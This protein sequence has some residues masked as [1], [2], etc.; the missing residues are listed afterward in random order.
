ML[1]GKKVLLCVT[2]GI[3]AYKS[4]DIAS[5][6]S[7]KGVSV[8]VVMS[9]NATKFVT[10]LSF[11]AITS[12]PVHI[13]SFDM[14]FQGIKH[15]SLAKNSDVIIIAPATANAI[16]KLA[17]GLADDLISLTVLATNKKVIIAPAMNVLM[18]ES[19]V[20][21]DNINILKKRGYS[22][23]E[24]EEGLLACGDFGKGK[25]A[26]INHI[27]DVITENLRVENSLKGKTVLVTTG[28]TREHLD[29]VRF[30]SNPSTGKM[31]YSVAKALID[32][33]ADV[34]LVTGKTNIPKNLN[35]KFIEVCSAIEMRDA[36]IDNI[37][38]VDAVVFSAAVADY[39]PESYF[40]N[41][42]KKSN[43]DLTVNLVRNP[44]IAKEVNLLGLNL[45]K[46]GFAAETQN[47]IE[48]AQEKLSKKGFD[49]IV[50][51]NIKSKNA[52]F[53]VDTNKASIIDKYGVTDY[54]V[55]TK[56]ELARII[57]DKLEKV[58]KD[59]CM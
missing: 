54:D 56:I 4:L 21:Q 58:L 31:G 37:K 47:L 40:D 22:F 32:K 39:R 18:Y 36:V 50:A 44:D 51:N 12:N 2:G 5:S 15:I 27:V 16:S 20:I 33:G 24:P 11:E 19:K 29:P 34:I 41:K 46:V 49:F 3:A 28:A 35:C 53:S 26:N 7:K 30:L 8:D 42:I 6:L 45:V 10:P 14:D 13:S 57:A 17:C 48:N 55:M 59:K 1:K 52:G 43:D 25:L 23:I 38:N 9:D